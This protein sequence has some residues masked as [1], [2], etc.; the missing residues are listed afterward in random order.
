MGPG[1]RFN[2]W[3]CCG[4]MAFCEV[5]VASKR[6]PQQQRGTS[7]SLPQDSARHTMATATRR[8]WCAFPAPALP[9]PA[10]LTRHAGSAPPP[11]AG[12]CMPRTEGPPATCPHLSGRWERVWLGP[13]KAGRCGRFLSHGGKGWTLDHPPLPPDSQARPHCGGAQPCTKTCHECL[14]PQT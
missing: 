10:S 14:P 4:C 7:L 12:S 11:S 13:L 8:L 9:G 1:F 2:K 6:K 5:D 3:W